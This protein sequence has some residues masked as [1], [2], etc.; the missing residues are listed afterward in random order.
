[1][2]I[3]VNIATPM[4]L[5]TLSIAVS[6]KTQMNAYPQQAHYDIPFSENHLHL[7][8]LF[9]TSAIHV[10]NVVEGV[11]IIPLPVLR[12]PVTKRLVPGTSLRSLIHLYRNFVS[13]NRKAMF[14]NY[15]IHRVSHLLRLRTSHHTHSMASPNL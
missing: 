7:Q 10:T 8:S 6:S 9:N 14:L 15:L 1:M 5:R 3:C 11:I 4:T 2:R 12:R 13:T